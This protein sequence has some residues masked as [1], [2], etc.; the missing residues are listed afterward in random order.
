[1]CRQK[2]YFRKAF[3][4]YPNEYAANY[5][6]YTLIFQAETLRRGFSAVNIRM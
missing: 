1:M 3:K 6:Y 5:I 4:I 2:T